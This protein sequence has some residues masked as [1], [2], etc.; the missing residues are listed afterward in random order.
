VNQSREIAIAGSLSVAVVLPDLFQR[1][2]AQRNFTEI[3]Q[4]GYA[5]RVKSCR[6]IEWAV[7]VANLI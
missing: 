4:S 3:Q 6:R 1:M 2:G 7:I 5:A